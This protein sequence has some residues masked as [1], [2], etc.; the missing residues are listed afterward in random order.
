MKIMI[1][2]GLGFIGSHLAE[3][4]VKQNHKLIL[5]TKTYSK[6]SNIDTIKKSVI[7]EKI[8]VTDFVKLEKSIQ[9]HKP[10][11]IVHLAGQTS[12]TKSFED[13]LQDIESNAK[14]TLFIL[15]TIKKLKLKCKFILGSTFIVVGRPKHLPVNE[16]TPCNPTTIYGINRL[17]SEYYCKIYNSVFGLDT[18]MFRI[19]NSFGP[20]EQYLSNKNA[21][22]HLIYKA[23]KG[24]DVTIFN[25]GK[26]FR[27]LIYVSDVI[28]AIITVMKK[29]KSGNLYWIS[30][31]KKVWFNQLG[32][33]LT[34]L[35]GTKV[36]YVPTPK[37]TKRVDVGN[38]V[39]DNSKLR[40]LGWKQR[41]DVKSG[42]QN[43]IKYFKSI[44]I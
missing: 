33:W 17:S 1:T 16:D 7:I 35:T 37:Y 30:S 32:K 24:K 26:F 31:G 11:V 43:T 27:D 3:E 41:T 40:T 9:K 15:E 34:E 36:K 22:N 38:F 5:L 8:D 28:S 14:S 6:K 20:R 12:H 25:Q 23:Y 4:L 10:N 39:V 29:G 13:P 21:I 44:E 2:G 19:T 18:L 42:I